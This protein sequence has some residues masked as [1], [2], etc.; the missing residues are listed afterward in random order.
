VLETPEF[1]AGKVHT[2]TLEDELLR[3][4]EEVPV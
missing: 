3:R 4:F 2:R 1:E